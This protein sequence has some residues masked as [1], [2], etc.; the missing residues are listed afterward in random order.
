MEAVPVQDYL[1]A[2][3][4]LL[5]GV[6]A[7]TLAQVDSA[8]LEG[9]TLVDLDRLGRSRPEVGTLLD[10]ALLLPHTERLQVGTKKENKKKTKNKKKLGAF[11]TL[12]SRL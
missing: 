2:P 6:P 8:S 3:M 4:P 10:D 5:A 12:R 11:T 9:L 7:A 1:A